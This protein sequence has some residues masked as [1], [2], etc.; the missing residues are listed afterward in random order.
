MYHDKR[1][2]GQLFHANVFFVL[3]LFRLI[4]CSMYSIFYLGPIH[5]IFACDLCMWHTVNHKSLTRS[6]DGGRG[7]EHGGRQCQQKR[8]R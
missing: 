3:D 2:V 5:A 7:T 8:G 6:N 4:T 1:N